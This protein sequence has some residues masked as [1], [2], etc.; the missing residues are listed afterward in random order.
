M[1]LSVFSSKRIS[2][3]MSKFKSSVTSL[4]HLCW[5]S[6]VKV[7]DFFGNSLHFK[8]IKKTLNP[9][10]NNISQHS[11]IAALY[12]HL[13]LR[14]SSGKAKNESWDLNHCNISIF[15]KLFPPPPQ[16]EKMTGG[17]GVGICQDE[18]TSFPGESNNSPGSGLNKPAWTG[19]M[20]SQ[21]FIC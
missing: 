18:L 21:G 2:Q 13:C 14:K 12:V 10:A 9:S 4:T 16:P 20:L 7:F 17:L 15:L 19:S 11:G 1:L 5:Q 8:W 6:T 3:L